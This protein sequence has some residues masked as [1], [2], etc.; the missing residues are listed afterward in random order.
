M[1][2]N[3]NPL[4]IHFRARFGEVGEIAIS[5]TD[6]KLVTD[7]MLHFGLATPQQVAAAAPVV[8]EATP[9]A[10]ETTP[11]KKSRKAAPA[12]TP[13]AIEEAA[14]AETAAESPSEG[15]AVAEAPSQDAP[16]ASTA[17]STEPS[18]SPATPEEAAAAVKAFGA[19]NGIDAARALLKQFGLAR[20][21]DITAEQAG[22]IVE[23]ASV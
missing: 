2:E 11:A 12:P 21:G 15:N 8:T 14:P 7:A 18:A 20:T 16:A 17:S 5:G 4:H 10:A 23:A 13:T 19:K 22:A 3:V 1:T 6:V 9:V